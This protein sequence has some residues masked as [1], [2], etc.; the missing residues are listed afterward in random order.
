MELNGKKL[1][2]G[3]QFMAPHGMEEA[4]LEIGKKFEALS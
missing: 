1:P 4:L 2:L 3:V